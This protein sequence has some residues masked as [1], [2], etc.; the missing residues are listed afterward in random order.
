MSLQTEDFTLID[1][2]GDESRGRDGWHGYFTECP[3]YKIHVDHIL[4]S[5]NGTA[6]LG[7]TTGSHVEP[8]VEERETIIWTAEISNNLV[9]EWRLYSDTE[10]VEKELGIR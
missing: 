2:E 5:G 4:T 1:Y 8:E 6:I 9:T 3:N 7:R 10:D